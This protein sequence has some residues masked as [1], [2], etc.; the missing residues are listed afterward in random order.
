MKLSENTINVLKNF[1]AINSNIVFRPGSNIKTIAEAKNIMANV[2]VEETFPDTE[3]GIYDLNEFLNVIGMFE[4]PELVFDSGM[5]FVT[6]VEGSRKVKYFFSDTSILTTITKDV[7]FPTPEVSFTL[8]SSELNDLRRAAS[9]LGVSDVVIYK[10][11]DEVYVKV[12]DSSDSTSNTFS[13]K[14]KAETKPDSDFSLVFNISN[15]KLMNGD[16]NV[17]ISSKL[18]S[19]FTNVKQQLEYYIALEKSSK[20][21]E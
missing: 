17:E 20:F 21:G 14:V 11:N 3:F 16:Y 10:E 4:D 2:T 8:T 1:S 9:A 12:T 13:V 18:I 15:F 5:K 19:K 6:I 7:N